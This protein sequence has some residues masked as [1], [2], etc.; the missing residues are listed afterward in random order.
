MVIS[1]SGRL[2]L[3]TYIQLRCNALRPRI[4][5]R[6]H[7]K[8]IY[9]E[10]LKKIHTESDKVVSE[11]SDYQYLINCRHIDDLDALQYLVTRVG[12]V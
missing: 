2:A 11:E 10:E 4:R 3:T 1:R 8:G 9:F 12:K 7:H 5:A 6:T